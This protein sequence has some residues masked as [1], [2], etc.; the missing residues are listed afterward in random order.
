[1]LKER[2]IPE[3]WVWRTLS[4]P[5][6]QEVG[7]DNNIHY[8]KSIPEYGERFLHIVVNPNVSPKKVITVFFDRRVRRQK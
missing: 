2:G 7:I 8:F 1:M 3:E 4:H 5:D 6:R